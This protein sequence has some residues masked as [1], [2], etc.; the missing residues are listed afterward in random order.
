MPFYQDINPDT[1]AGRR[2]LNRLLRLRKALAL[3]VP[4]RTFRETLLLATWN[5]RDFDKASY[6]KRLDESIYYIAEVIDHFDIVAVQEVYKD[7]EGLKRVM[8]VLGGNWKFII[9]D[10]TER[11]GDTSQGN[12]ERMAFLY[13]SRKVRFGGLAGELVLPP[14]RDENGTLQPVSQIWRTP[15]YVG[16][17]SGWTDFIL[18]TVHIA[19]ASSTANPEVRVREIREVAQFLKRRTEDKTA[20]SRNFILLGDFNIFGTDD[21]TFQQITDAGFEV[22]EELLAFRSNA[23]QTR[24]YDQIALRPRPGSLDLTGRAGVFNYYQEVFCDTPEDKATYLP[25]MPNFETTLEGTPRSEQSK[26]HYY[27]TYWRTHQ[28]SDHLPM[29]VELQIDYTDR[30]LERKRDEA[31][32]LTPPP[33][34]PSD[35]DM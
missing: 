10:A 8:K 34:I 13:D 15:F 35:S 23:T 18:T 31:D 11:T 16:F 27:Q 6:G 2:T 33:P 30:Y 17:R 7:L 32:D 4:A 28:M 3:N 21:E 29:W 9:T 5:I 19:W 1:P 22:P 24:H 20:W 14:V 25:F 26:N 12:D